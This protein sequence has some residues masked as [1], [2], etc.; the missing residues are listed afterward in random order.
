MSMPERVEAR[1]VACLKKFKPIV[2]DALKADRSE[3]GLSA[4]A[5]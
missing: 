4:N 3:V 5:D 1:I 2:D